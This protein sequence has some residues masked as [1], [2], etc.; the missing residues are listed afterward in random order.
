MKK[1]K[2]ITIVGALIIGALGSGLWEL[3]KP[4]LSLLGAASLNVVTLGLDSLRDGLYAE[5]ANM[6][7]ERAALAI[8]SALQGLLLSLP[9]LLYMRFK[10]IK[11]KA[12]IPELPVNASKEDWAVYKVSVDEKIKVL[13]RKSYISMALFILVVTINF[14]MFQRI[15]YISKVSAHFDKMVAMAAPYMEVKDVLFVKSQFVQVSGRSDYEMVVSKLY[16]VLDEN[17]IPAQRLAL[18]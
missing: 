10:S 11:R 3:I 2:I 15:S 9:V 8:L 5:A 12:D 16:V 13:E 6:Q 4:L 1:E 17:K 18:F 7:P 14:L